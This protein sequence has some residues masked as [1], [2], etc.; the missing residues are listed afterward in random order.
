MTKM[1]TKLET[2]MS[3]FFTPEDSTT[4]SGQGDLSFDVSSN[5]FSLGSLKVLFWVGA[6]MGG[7]YL[8]TLI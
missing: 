7:F 6:T 2:L 1:M 8:I 4:M 5:S 3:Y